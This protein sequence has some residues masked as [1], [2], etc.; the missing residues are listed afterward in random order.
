VGLPYH[1][2]A[3]GGAMS[4]PASERCAIDAREPTRLGG[5]RVMSVPTLGALVAH[6][7]G[8]LP[9]APAPEG[10]GLAAGDDERPGGDLADVKGQE[11]ARRTLEVAAA[12]GHNLLMAAPPGAGKTLLARALP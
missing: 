1:Q 10:G 3:P 9:I 12:G 6:L 11:H 5:L 2:A 7:R 4:A 8:E